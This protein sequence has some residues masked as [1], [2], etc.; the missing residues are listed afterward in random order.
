[1]VYERN[2]SREHAKVKNYLSRTISTR[3]VKN[4][5]GFKYAIHT[6]RKKIGNLHPD[7]H[8]ELCNGVIVGVEYQKSFVLGDAIARKIREYTENNA[9]SLYIFGPGNHLRRIEGKENSIRAISWDAEYI[10]RMTGEVYIAECNPECYGRTHIWRAR[11][12]D[13]K[14][15]T[16]MQTF[17][18]KDPFNRPRKAVLECSTVKVKFKRLDDLVLQPDVVTSPA[19]EQTYIA[20]FR[21][22]IYEN[23]EWVYVDE[24]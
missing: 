5:G 17:G 24:E 6:E 22:L 15:P 3:N 14:F 18:V 10:A 16:T 2:E 23:N 4:E 11:I 13:D 19:N 9:C 1:M 12:I 21:K 7:V 8:V 20:R